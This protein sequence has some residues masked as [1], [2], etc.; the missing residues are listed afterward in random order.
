M[1]NEKRLNEKLPRTP[2]NTSLDELE[3]DEYSDMPELVYLSANYNS[4]VSTHNDKN[5]IPANPLSDEIYTR[6]VPTVNELVR[7]SK[8]TIL[9]GLD[10]VD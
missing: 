9:H 6:I 8:T 1:R 4:N 3:D 5:L 7:P 10:Q 2:T